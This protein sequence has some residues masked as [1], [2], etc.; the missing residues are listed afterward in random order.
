MVNFD[1]NH[2]AQNAHQTHGLCSDAG[3][4]LRQRLCAE[5]IHRRIG[6]NRPKKSPLN[7]C[8][9]AALT[10]GVLDFCP[11]DG[12]SLSNGGRFQGDQLQHRH[13]GIQRGSRSAGAA[14][15]AR[16]AARPAS[17]AGGGDLR[18]RRQQ[19]FRPRGAAGARQARPAL[20]LYRPVAQFRP[21][22]RHHRRHGRDARQSD[23]RHGRRSAGPARR[24]S[25]S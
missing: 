20:P 5:R 1:L 14:A 19:R 12:G 4:A 17:R 9:K 25:S 13:P 22:G 6:E 10:I 8:R 2:S 15:P 23:H 18:R 3:G 16:P 24:S 7:G 21:P 11:F